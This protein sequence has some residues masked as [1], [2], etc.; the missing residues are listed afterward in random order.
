MQPIAPTFGKWGALGIQKIILVKP[1][2]ESS[3]QKWVNGVYRGHTMKSLYVMVTIL[4]F[5]LEGSRE[6]I[7]GF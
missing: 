7:D 1:R 5:Y 4:H 3:R 2:E 6:G